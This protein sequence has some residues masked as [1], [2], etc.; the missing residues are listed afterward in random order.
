MFV[1]LIKEFLL[2]EGVSPNWFLI[3]DKPDNGSVTLTFDF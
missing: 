1:H 2:Q 3:P